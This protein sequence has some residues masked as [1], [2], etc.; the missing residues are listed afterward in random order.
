MADISENLQ[1]ILDSRY[2]RDVRQAIHDAI[3]NCYD[4]G[5]AGATDMEARQHINQLS[6][7]VSSQGRDIALLNS[8][9]DALKSVIKVKSFTNTISYA[10]GTVGT[11]TAS[12]YV[13]V[14]YSGYTPIAIRITNAGSWSDYQLHCFFNANKNAVYTMAY[15][16]S[17]KA[18][19]N[20]TVAFDVV[21][22]KNDYIS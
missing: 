20:S 12:S 7:T 4:D 10:A 8:N 14:S 18:V 16:A 13:D 17:A 11:F 9:V 22:V 2:G 5:R 19:S 1:K 21:Y 15:R 6:Q 3:Q